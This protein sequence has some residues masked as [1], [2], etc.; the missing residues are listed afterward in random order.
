V[1]LAVS[2]RDEWAVELVHHKVYLSNPPPEVESFSISHGYN[3]LLASRGWDLG[4]VWFRVGAGPV[5]THPESTVRGRSLDEHGG[6]I[7]GGYY[8]SGGAIAAMAERRLVL[9][10]PL[11]ASFGAMITAAFARVPVQGGDADVPNLAIHVL[12]GIGVTVGTTR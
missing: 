11:Y 7:G 12:A 3:M 6:P 10:G 4:S 9:V 8:L 1:I 5:I 2:P